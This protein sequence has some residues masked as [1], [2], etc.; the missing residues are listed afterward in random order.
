[1]QP[2]ALIRAVLAPHHTENAQLGVARLAPQDPDDLPVLRLGQL[3]RGDEIRRDRGHAWA[4]AV[5]M[6][7]KT[8][9]PSVEPI[10]SS[11]A[12]S[13]CGIMPITLRS[14]LR[15]PAM[16]RADPLGLSR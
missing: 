7:L 12:R 1:M 4:S 11:A 3:M 14:R 10:S 6:D 9:S 13:G 15:I 8:T 16:S 2:R 5:T